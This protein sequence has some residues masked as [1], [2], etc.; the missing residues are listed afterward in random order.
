MDLDTRA[1]TETESQKENS[2]M[3]ISA[4]RLASIG[5]ELQWWHDRLLQE[6]VDALLDSCGRVSLQVV[7]DYADQHERYLHQLV[8]LPPKIRDQQLSKLND[9]LTLHVVLLCASRHVR[10]A[11]QWLQLAADMEA[12]Q[13]HPKESA[14]ATVQTAIASRQAFLESTPSY[15]PFWDDN[16][17][18]GEGLLGG[19]ARAAG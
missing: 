13:W 14:R 8:G 18:L 4:K 17:P 15:W 7:Q 6:G 2:Q 10:C 11:L 5:P 9:R 16:D 12:G 19:D 1:P 3:K